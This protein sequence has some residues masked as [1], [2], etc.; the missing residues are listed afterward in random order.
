MKTI[1]SLHNKNIWVLGGAGYL[2]Q[3]VVTLLHSLGAKVICIDLAERAQEFVSSQSFDGQVRAETLDVSD[4]DQIDQNLDDLLAKYAVPD[5]LVNL[6]FGSTASKLEDL[7]YQDFDKANQMN[8]TSTFAICRKVGAE[9][10]KEGKGNLV[11][12]SSMYGMGSPYPEVYDPTLIKN[13]IEY[14]VGKAGVIQMTK[15]LA[16]HYGK[17]GIRCNCISPGPFPNPGVQQS[18]PD[19]VNKLAEKSPMGRIGKA[20]EIAGAVAF[21]LTDASSYINGHNLVVDGGWTS[22]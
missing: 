13:P 15:Y 16:V 20:E 11:L 3:S 12:F 10:L 9:M 6:T 14:G 7:Q 21:L 2:G 4:I 22:W 5:G 1:F 18:Q 8:L 19:F 17:G